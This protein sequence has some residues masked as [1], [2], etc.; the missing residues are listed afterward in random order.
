MRLIGLPVR[1]GIMRRV[2]ITL[3]AAVA[4][5]V[6]VGCGGPSTPPPTTV[7]VTAPPAASGE[8]SDSS[9][10]AGARQPAH[11]VTLPEVADQNGAIVYEE[12]QQLG[13]TKVQYASQDEKDK[14]VLNPANWT[15]TKI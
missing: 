13:L 7:T 15:A 4:A 5:L 3:A 1:G 14:V 6:L 10:S 9:P 8:Q 11:Q 2:V 12:L